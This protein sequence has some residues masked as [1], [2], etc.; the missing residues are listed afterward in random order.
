MG[1]LNSCLFLQKLLCRHWLY[2]SK[3]AR[4]NSPSFE[5]FPAQGP[6]KIRF[7]GSFWSFAFLKKILWTRETQFLK[8]CKS[9]LP[10]IKKSLDETQKPSITIPVKNYHLLKK[11]LRK[12]KLR[13][14]EPFLNKTT[15]KNRKAVRS[16]SENNPIKL[17][18]LWTTIFHLDRQSTI[19]TA[20]PKK[21]YQKFHSI[22]SLRVRN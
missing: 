3:I 9:F 17:L 19:L 16:K 2:F 4:R 8:R 18:Y 12:H 15:A 11:L 1:L 14:W 20:L 13:F 10:K 21:Y 7:Y 22:L 6:K 5:N